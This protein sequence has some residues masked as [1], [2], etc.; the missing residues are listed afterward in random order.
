MKNDNLNIVERVKAPTPK[1][2]KIVRTIGIT[3]TAVGS[4]ILAAPVAIPATIVTVAG[5]LTLGGTIATAVAQTAIQAEESEQ[6]QEN[7]K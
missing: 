2:F 3:L 4:A 1:W 5:Y 7:E 6:K